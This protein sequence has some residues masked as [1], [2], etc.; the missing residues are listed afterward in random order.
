MCSAGIEHVHSKFAI[1]R[2]ERG[3]V[4]QRLISCKPYFNIQ[5]GIIQLAVLLE[6]RLDACIL[7]VV[8]LFSVSANC[9]LFFSTKRQM[10]QTVLFY[11]NKIVLVEN[12]ALVKFIRNYILDSCGIFSISSLVRI[13]MTS[14]PAFTLL[15]VQKILS[16]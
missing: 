15:F 16:I 3:M 10:L 8:S 12:R 2:I 4:Q 13:S 6:N 9:S 7:N 14:F 1:D 11:I 5:N